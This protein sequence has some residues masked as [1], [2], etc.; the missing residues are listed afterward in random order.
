MRPQ[1]SI[2]VNI[3]RISTTSAWVVRGETEG[4]KVFSDSDDR[5][6]IIVPCICRRREANF[7]DLARY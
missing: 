7:N 6:K 5:I 1:Y 3:V 4:V 2:L